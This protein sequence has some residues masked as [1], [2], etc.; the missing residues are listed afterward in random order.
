MFRVGDDSEPPSENGTYRNESPE[1]PKRK[2]V[3]DMDGIR[4]KSLAQLTRYVYFPV[5]FFS[6]SWNMDLT[7]NQKI[8]NLAQISY[9]LIFS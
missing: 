5:F 1:E 4:K 3:C 8:T 9:N 7:V 2:S 6:T